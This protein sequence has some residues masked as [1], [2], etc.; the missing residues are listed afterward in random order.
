[1]CADEPNRYDTVVLGAGLAG[2]Y[3]AYLLQKQGYSVCILE[4]RERIG[5]RVATWHPPDTGQHGELGA[6]FIDSNHHRLLSLARTLG[7]TIGE[8]PDFW[9]I[10]PNRA[11]GREAHQA[12][13]RFWAGVL[14][15]LAPQIPDPSAPW[16]APEPVRA[17][18]FR[19]VRDWA[20]ERGLWQAGE[21][22]FRRYAR[23]LEAAEP[24]QVSMFSLVAQERFYGKGVELG[25]FRIVEGTESLPMA[26]AQHLSACGVSLRLGAI[27]EKVV[28]EPS[29]VRVSYRQSG[30]VRTVVARDAV[31]AL[32][33]PVIPQIEWEPPLS[34]ARREALALAGAGQVVR[35]LILFRRRFWRQNAPR[36]IAHNP[37]ISAIWEETDG[38]PGKTGILS[39]WVGGEPARKWATRSP[40]ERIETCLQ[41]MEVMY[42]GCRADSL[43]AESYAWGADPFAQHAYIYH[44]PGYLTQ[45][46]P[47][48]REPEGRLYFAGDYLSLF[49]GYMEG[50]LESAENAVNA[51]LARYNSPDGSANPSRD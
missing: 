43:H 9:G 42:P 37:D 50:A 21:P 24:E 31:V 5:G 40:Q 45:A 15:E 1:M 33:F 34:A 30:Q 22:L 26:L 39:F 48:L 46:L 47:L 41:V 10:T 38:M 8:R 14:N 17:L 13:R 32:P 19:T 44:A 51:L 6:E 35:T 28:Q 4:A 2:L 36:R 7:L 29:G 12:W 18:D 23:N 20:E 16:A 27:V 25:A 11:I 49:V 3:A